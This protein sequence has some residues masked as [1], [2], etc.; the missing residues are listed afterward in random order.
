M[1]LRRL[2][3]GCVSR[4]K[5]PGCLH[6]RPACKRSASAHLLQ[7]FRFPQAKLFRPAACMRTGRSL[8]AFLQPS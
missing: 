5:R 7:I 6:K 4:L 8:P 1:F 2:L 3:L